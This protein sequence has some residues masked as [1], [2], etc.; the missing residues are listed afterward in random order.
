MNKDNPTD[1]GMHKK[2]VVSTRQRAV[3][4]TARRLEKDL[5]QSF[6]NFK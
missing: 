4:E 6:K 2:A 1:G 3:N 5:L